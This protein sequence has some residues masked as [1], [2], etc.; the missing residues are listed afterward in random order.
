MNRVHLL[1]KF[2]TFCKNG[3]DASF[4]KVFNILEKWTGCTSASGGPLA[5]RRKQSGSP[6]SSPVFSS[7]FILFSYFSSSPQP[8]SQAA[9]VWPGW[10]PAWPQ[11]VPGWGRR[12]QA[13]CRAGPPPCPPPPPSHPLSP[14][15][16]VL[17]NRS[18]G[19]RPSLGYAGKEVTE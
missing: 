1:I 19:L 2:L 11:W 10:R 17:G 15:G 7:F 5:S 6:A 8:P 13:A 14:W 3:Q 9:L 18:W 16:Q 4:N 12:R